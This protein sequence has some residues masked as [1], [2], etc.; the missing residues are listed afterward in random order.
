[1]GDEADLL[2]RPDFVRPH[3][4]GVEVLFVLIED[5]AVDCGVVLVRVVL[6]V[7]LQATLLVDGEN[8]S[9]TGE[10]VERISVD[11]VRR[12]VGSKN[13]DGTSL[14]VGIVGFGVASHWV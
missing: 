12:L 2:V 11:V 5:H 1:M 3:V 7:L 6:D 4:G 8:V 9:I 10:V 13:K 14:G